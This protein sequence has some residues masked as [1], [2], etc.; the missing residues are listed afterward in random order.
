MNYDV[1]I[2]YRIY[3]G[4]S[5]V[6]PIYSDNKYQLSELC[7]KSFKA[8][9][10]SLKVKIWVLLDN[11]PNAYK[12]LFKKYFDESDLEFVEFYGIGNAGTFGK[13]LEILLN[14]SASH[15]VYFAEDDYF[16]LP[17]QFQYMVNFINNNKNVD[18]VTPY[19]HND[20]YKNTLHQ[21]KSTEL[22]SNTKEWRTVA[23]TCMTFLTTKKILEETYK[24]FNTYTK[25]NY[26]ASLWLSIT[27][28]KINELFFYVNSIFGDIQIKRILFKCWYH[29]W[30]QILFGQKRKLWAPMPSIA[31][32]MDSLHLAPFIN[33]EAKFQKYL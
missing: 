12:N 18:F 28:L 32:H 1:A 30:K 5:K 10:G 31:T 4:L 2:A 8:S 15:L 16:Y 22:F 17:E 24:I 11:C 33:W 29:C 23:T 14:Q 9:L 3:P 21:Y 25:N 13:Q 26:D 6:P 7:L 27:K 19:D 20:Y